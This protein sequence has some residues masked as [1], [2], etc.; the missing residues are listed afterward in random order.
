MNI[1]S[2][3][4]FALMY[5]ASHIVIMPQNCFHIIPHKHKI[6]SHLMRV[7]IILFFILIYLLFFF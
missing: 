6:S 2:L 5:V 1:S 3:L 4:L 7:V